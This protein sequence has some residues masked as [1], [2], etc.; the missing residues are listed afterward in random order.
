[1]SRPFKEFEFDIYAGT[2]ERFEVVVTPRDADGDPTNE[3]VDDWDF[4]FVGKTD[5][6]MSDEQANLNLTSAAGDIEVIDSPTCTLR[7]TIAPAK[8]KRLLPGQRIPVLCTL[9]GIKPVADPDPDEEY[10]LVSGTLYV[11]MPAS[12]A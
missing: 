11:T 6:G 4:E 9:R 3:T 8:Y 2:T 5:L 10:A 1:M 7:V 12:R